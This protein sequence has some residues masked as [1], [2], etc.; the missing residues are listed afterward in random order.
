MGEES[1]VYPF[2]G[3]NQSLV[4]YRALLLKYITH[5]GSCEGVTFISDGQ[6]HVS[7]VVF[8]DQEWAELQTLDAEST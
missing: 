8:A 6:R 1:E 5:V 3:M 4:D 7:G 2:E